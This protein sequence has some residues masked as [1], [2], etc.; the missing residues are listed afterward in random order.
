MVTLFVG[1]GFDIRGALFL[2]AVALTAWFGGMVPGLTA[3]VLSVFS[4]G[5]FFQPLVPY[6]EIAGIRVPY[7]RPFPDIVCV[8]GADRL[9]AQ[10]FATQGRGSA[11]RERATLA[12]PYRGAAAVGL[13]RRSGW[14]V[15]LLQHAMDNLHRSSRRANCSAGHG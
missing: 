9:L 11:A 15:R 5:Y 4:L 6:V 2:T 1:R 8:Y 13:G 10:C 14:W 12:K 7:R 3:L